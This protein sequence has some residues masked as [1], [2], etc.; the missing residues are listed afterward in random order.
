MNKKKKLFFAF[1]SLLLLVF[2][3]LGITLGYLIVNINTKANIFTLGYAQ[4]ELIEDEWNKQ[5]T[6][7]R[8]VYPEREINKD[9]LVRNVGTTPLYVYIE[10]QIPRKNVRTIDNN[11][12]MQSSKEQDLFSYDIKTSDW[13][14]ISSQTTDD[15]TTKVYGYT[16]ILQ[17]A[18]E[19]STLFDSVK[20]INIVE[21]ELEMGTELN[22]PVRAYGI[23]TDYLEDGDSIEEKLKK[24]YNQY[25]PFI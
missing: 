18:E 5:N 9:P 2:V 21:G 15:Y 24:T 20:Y 6:E 3:I 25:K 13:V 11:G 19:T 8:T 16:K 10:V 17:P 23:Q 4:I 14:E 1:I 7:D 12:D 22:M